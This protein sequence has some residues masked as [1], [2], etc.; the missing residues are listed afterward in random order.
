MQRNSH[1]RADV[2]PEAPSPF[3]APPNREKRQRT[4]TGRGPHDRFKETDADRT[5][6]WPF[7]PGVTYGPAEVQYRSLKKPFRK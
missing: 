7:L 4:R 2:P 5:R 1:L 3:G 6:A